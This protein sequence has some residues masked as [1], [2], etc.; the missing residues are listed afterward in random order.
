MD[1]SG[2]LAVKTNDLVDFELNPT[3]IQNSGFLSEMIQDYEAVYEKITDIPRLDLP[4]VDADSLGKI[5]E[6]TTFNVNPKVGSEQNCD[7]EGK[8]LPVSGS[9]PERVDEAKI[10]KFRDDILAVSTPFAFKVMMQANFLDCKD[11]VSELCSAVREKI[12]GKSPKDM[13]DFFGVEFDES[14]SNLNKA[15][16]F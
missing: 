14:K 2:N 12:T 10:M 7:F 9:V 3:F 11:L 8:P 13:A 15:S 4:N 6:W 5:I 1:K 16:S